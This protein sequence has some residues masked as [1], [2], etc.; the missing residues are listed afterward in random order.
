MDQISTK[1]KKKA[2]NAAQ[3]E[4]LQP[5]VN[6]TFGYRLAQCIKRYYWLYIF[7]IPMLVWYIIFHYV[8]MGGIV[9]AFKNYK[10]YEP[11]YWHSKWVGMKWF[12]K[13]FKNPYFW[14]LIENTLTLSL[15]QL[16]TFPLPIIVALFFNELRS[17]KF[18][19]VAQTIM[20]APHFISIVV[21]V[22]MMQLFF[23][24]QYGMVNHLI[25]ALGGEPYS[26]MIE[27]EAFAHMFIWSGVWQGLGW[28]CIIYIAALS[29]VDPG[30][31]EA[32]K[33]DG[34]SR[35]QRI[36][37]INLPTI[38]PTV[39]ITFIMKV[40]QIMTIGADKVLLMRNNLNV[41]KAEVISTYVYYQGLLSS[42]YGY[43][44]AVGLF[45]NVINLVMLLIVNYVSGKL[46]ETSLF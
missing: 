40:G 23:S 7:I 18:K 13:F 8:P 1:Q 29:S 19:K 37:H 30:L 5:L 16:A 35:L 24:T 42:D 43:G 14:R 17:A 10:G 31:H 39:V 25:K 27:E 12:L 45:T 28:N 32:A 44:A 26:F 11:T 15:Y 21:L 33:L 36:W 4:Q 9:I 38:L 20:Y 46:S 41:A 22:S 2:C 6:K 3:G 34:A